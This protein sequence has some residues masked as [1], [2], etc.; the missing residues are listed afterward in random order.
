MIVPDR[1][2]GVIMPGQ[3]RMTVRDLLTPG[4][5]ASNSVQYVKET[6]FT[7]AAAT[8]SETT[9]PAKPQSDI[10]F[11]VVTSNVTTIAHW[12]SSVQGGQPNELEADL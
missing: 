7:N 1:I 9:G 11:D 12:V 4:R 3:R 2:P 8:V 6:G 10:K 5:T